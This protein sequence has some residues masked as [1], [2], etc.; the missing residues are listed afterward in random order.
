MDG[1]FDLVQRALL[2]D[3]QRA[4]QDQV[5]G[6]RPDDVDAEHCGSIG[7]G[8]H[9]HKAIGVAVSDGLAVVRQ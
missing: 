9:L 7:I 6:V 3:G 4:L 1:V 5:A 8:D 2:L